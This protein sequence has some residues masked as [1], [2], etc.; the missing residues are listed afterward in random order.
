MI[1]YQRILKL[2]S[3]F[4][5]QIDQ[6]KW[7]NFIFV[8]VIF[9]YTRR[10]SFQFYSST[11]LSAYPWLVHIPFQLNDIQENKYSLSCL[12]TMNILTS[13]Y[14]RSFNIQIQTREYLEACQIFLKVHYLGINLSLSK[15]NKLSCIVCFSV[16]AMDTPPWTTRERWVHRTQSRATTPSVHVTLSRAGEVSPGTTLS[17]PTSGKIPLENQGFV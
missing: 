6:W 17:L 15:K 9:L 2:E 10:K 13:T 1:K 12:V 5:L 11:Y 3:S 8:H 14:I 7:R 4:I 16:I